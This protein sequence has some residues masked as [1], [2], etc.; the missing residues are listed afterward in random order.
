[1]KV[2]FDLALHINKIRKNN[3]YFDTFINKSSLSAGVILLH[4]GQKDTQEPHDTDEIYYIISGTGFL[5]INKTD[6]KVSKN[7]IYFVAKNTKHY[8]HA[9]KTELKVLY[10]FGNNDSD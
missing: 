4:P 1:M 9:N 10:F 8:F 3:F 2:E 6:Y 7:K 5:K